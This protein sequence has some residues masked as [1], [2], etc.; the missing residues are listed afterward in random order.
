ML[1]HGAASLSVDRLGDEPSARNNGKYINNCNGAASTASMLA[2]SH[3]FNLYRN[4]VSQLVLPV[5]EST[6][7][8][9]RRPMADPALH[10]TLVRD[11]VEGIEC[12]GWLMPLADQEELDLDRCSAFR[13]SASRSAA[14]DCDLHPKLVAEDLF[15]RAKQAPL[16]LIQ[17]PIPP[18]TIAA[19]LPDFVS[20]VGASAAAAAATVPRLQH[21]ELFAS[22][23]SH[24]RSPRM[25]RAMAA[26]D[27]CCDS[28]SSFASHINKKAAGAA[29]A[30]GT[31]ARSGIMC[32]PAEPALG[33]SRQLLASGDS[34]KVSVTHFDFRSLLQHYSS[35]V[36]LLSPHH[37]PAAPA[38]G[39]HL[40]TRR[41]AQ[42]RAQQTT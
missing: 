25:L 8:E 33:S 11:A 6:L 4:N 36:Q 35:H 30:G 40:L 38:P 26:G 29:A 1:S 24:P 22:A 19:N 12:E 18:A 15:K 9:R 2:T 10:V 34:P 23:S 31:V 17:F 41:C 13:V 21:R 14:A 20:S 37:N 7:K 16:S 27:G 28:G 42:N 39:R 3:D 5:P 32:V